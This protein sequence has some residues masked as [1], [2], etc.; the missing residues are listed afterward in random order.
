MAAL[1][2]RHGDLLRGH[3]V[4]PA[5]AE[6]LLA[7]G[8]SGGFEGRGACGGFWSGQET[9][10]GVQRTEPG[11]LSA[12]PGASA[13]WLVSVVLVLSPLWVWFVGAARGARGPHRSPPAMLSLR[14]PSSSHSTVS[15]SLF[16]SFLCFC[17][18]TASSP[19][20]AGAQP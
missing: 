2:Y 17:P 13:T 1:F 14:L 7:R 19:R 11:M 15:F 12:A 8:G 16:A 5:L 4:I 9:P 6:H 10:A 3:S 18:K 20:R